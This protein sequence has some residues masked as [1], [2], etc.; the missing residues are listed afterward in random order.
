MS[1]SEVLR[2][3]QP[4]KDGGIRTVNFFNGRLLTSRDLSREQ[5]AWRMSDARLGLALGDGVAFG[6]EVV[7]DDTLV[8]AAGPVV[9]VSAGVAVNRE[10]RAMRLVQDTSIAVTRRFDAAAAEACLFGP[11]AETSGGRYVVGAGV[12]VLTIAPSD[13]TEGRAATNGLDPSNVRCN[14][15]A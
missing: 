11:C 9:R 12:Y 13:S 6:L 2:L 3:Q 15:D 8:D 7:R 10:G 14:V 4:L 5:E 1:G